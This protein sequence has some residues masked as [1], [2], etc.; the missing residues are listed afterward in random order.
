[1]SGTWVVKVIVEPSVE[2]FTRPYMQAK[3]R[4]NGITVVGGVS[5]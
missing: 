1:M 3:K 2:K 4:W 5:A